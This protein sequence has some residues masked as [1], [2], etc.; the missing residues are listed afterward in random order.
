MYSWNIKPLAESH[1]KF[2]V[3]LLNTTQG[4]IIKTCE[5]LCTEVFLHAWKHCEEEMMP[6]HGKNGKFIPK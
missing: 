2:I 6:K 3:G 1:T 4:V 5:Y